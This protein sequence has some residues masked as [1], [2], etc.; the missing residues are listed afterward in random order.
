MQ[1]DIRKTSNRN[2]TISCLDKINKLN[3]VSYD[4]IDKHDV[5]EDVGIIAQELKKILPRAVKENTSY[6]PNMYKNATHHLQNNNIAMICPCFDLNEGDTV[7]LVINKNGNEFE[8]SEKVHS[9]NG[10]SFY[11]KPW[12]NYHQLDSV[13][14][15]GTL[16]HDFLTVDKGQVGVLAAGG[17]KE[18]YEIAMN[19]QK[20]IDEQGL[21]LSKIAKWLKDK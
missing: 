14:V 17:V 2:K 3:M 11:I 6:I 5:G 13:L 19:Q 4:M 20:E 21:I 16:V 7:R 15:Y 1:S 9:P 8:Y 18:L 10:F 12:E